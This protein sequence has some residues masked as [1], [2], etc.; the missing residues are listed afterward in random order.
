MSR[1]TLIL[2]FVVGAAAIVVSRYLWLPANDKA[3]TDSLT[4]AFA[5]EA[6]DMDPTK[7]AAGIDYYFI[8]QIF[9]GL[10][11]V[12]ADGKF[13]NWLAESW[14]VLEE[15]GKTI[16]DVRIR[17][18]VKFH[19]GD[20]LTAHDFEF[21]FQRQR[22]PKISRWSHNQ[23]MVERFEIIDDLHFRLH[24]N[25]PDVTYVSDYPVLRLWAIPKHYFQQVGDDGFARAP[26][27]TGPWKFVSRK[28]NESLQLEAFAD[29]WN[30][31]HRPHVKHLTIKVIPEDLTRI[32]ALKTGAVDW[33]DA[34]PP[35][36]IED[37]RRTPGITTASYVSPNNMFLQ[38]NTH[39]PNSPFNDLRVRQA[40]AHTI[41]VDAIIK[42]VLFGQGERY[43][44]IG[45]GGSGHD[46]TLLPYEY[47]PD[48]A[49]ALLREAGYPN[50]FDTPCYNLTTP[51]EV[52]IK[53]VGEAMFAYLTAVGIR[54]KV[55]GLEYQAWLNIGRRGRN[56]PPEMDGVVSW[57]WGHGAGNDPGVAWTGHV[58]SFQPG[59]GFGS[60]SYTDDP[61]LDELIKAQRRTFDP[62]ER[63]ALLK[64]IARI[65]HEQLLGGLPTYRPYV[66]FAWRTDK[67]E[68]KPW[69][70]A[71]WRSMQEIGIKSP[72]PAPAQTA[73]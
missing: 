62:E 53:E 16:I 7:S 1:R 18:N 20:P 17:P 69:P 46:P 32:G 3:A 21:A 52:N 44:Q 24:F 26:V 14:E 38:F 6:T 12:D 13:I 70:D 8:S 5:G 56:A 37:V 25:E 67:V 65:K 43:T 42:N 2:A 23:A 30:Q 9:E 40:V 66:T 45:S 35:A 10:V 39:M 51:R 61:L 73:E 41:D 58:H 48:K 54:C 63:A 59:A 15:D 64:R 29:Y 36:M 47:N 11:R 27:G 33:I 72:E 60:Y 22:D 4:L 55:V 71:F 57:M 68:F 31:E 28:V 50:G 34:V 19:N 49:R